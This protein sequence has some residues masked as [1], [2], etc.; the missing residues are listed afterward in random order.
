VLTV[1]G[2]VMVVGNVKIMKLVMAQAVFV[3]QRAPAKLAVLMMVATEN[4]K[5]EHVQQVLPVRQELVKRI[6]SRVMIFARLVIL[7]MK[8]VVQLTL[9]LIAGNARFLLAHLGHILIGVLVVIFIILEDIIN[10]GHMEQLPHL[11]VWV[12]GQL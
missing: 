2:I 5:P 8:F 10:G 7:V 11:F 12:V 4:A 6:A 9:R 1:V 3:I